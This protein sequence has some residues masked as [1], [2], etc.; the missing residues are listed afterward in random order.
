MR[1]SCHAAPI[2]PRA[3]AIS[4]PPSKPR[5]RRTWILAFT[6]SIV[7]LDSTSSVMVLPVSVLTKICRKGGGARQTG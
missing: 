7:S 1:K 4:M 5:L 6:F 3:H 2:Y